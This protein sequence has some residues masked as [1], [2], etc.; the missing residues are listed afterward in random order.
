MHALLL[1]Q[2]EVR[3]LPRASSRRCCRAMTVRPSAAAPVFGAARD[4]GE[5][6]VAHVEHDEPDRRAA[7]GAQLPRGIVA[8]ETELV[9]R[10]LH[11]LHGSGRTFSGWF[12]T[13][14]TVP[15][16]TP[17]RSATS[18]T[19]DRRPCCAS[20]SGIDSVVR[21]ATTHTSAITETV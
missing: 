16:E 14:E 11:P 17:A 21:T 8:H 12:I 2:V 15:T 10:G 4:V 9:D 6:R 18:L 13:F 3:D 20:S 7:A 19:L 1:E 5:E